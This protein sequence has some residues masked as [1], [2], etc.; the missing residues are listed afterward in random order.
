[1]A[2]STSLEDRSHTG[3][4]SETLYGINIA[5]RL[6]SGG[7][8]GSESD[9]ILTASSDLNQPIQQELSQVA[10]QL[11]E[12]E[13]AKQ[14]LF[15]AQQEVIAQKDELQKLEQQ[16]SEAQQEIKALNGEL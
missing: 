15:E 16:L 5:S 1:M 8:E 13:K 7:H 2:N 10:P 9:T 14:Q 4:T 3:P 12:A 11:S 6:S